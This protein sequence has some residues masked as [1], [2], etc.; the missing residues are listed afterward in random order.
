MESSKLHTNQDRKTVINVDSILQAQSRR[1]KSTEVSKNILPEVDLGNLLLI[2]RQPVD[3]Q[4]L[5]SDIEISLQQLARDNTQWLINEIWKLPTQQMEDA[6][7]VQ[8]PEPTTI[9]AREK[10]IPKP[11]PPTKWEQYAKAKGIQKRKRGKMTF[12]EKTQTYKRRWGYK[13]VTDDSN[14]WVKEVPENAD[15]YEDQFEVAR[16][17]KKER[18]AKN[19][20]QRLRNIERRQKGKSMKTKAAQEEVTKAIKDAQSSTASHGVFTK[21]LPQE[22]RLRKAGVRRKLPPNLG[23]VKSERGAGLEIADKLRKAPILNIPKAVSMNPV[24][25]DGKKS[26]KGRKSKGNF[27]QGK[28]AKMSNRNFSQKTKKSSAISRS[29]KK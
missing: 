2:D 15:P 13:S 21:I 7:L 26:K 19:E 28:R 5:Q 18:I 10:P 3:P 6:L 17:A 1:Y 29:K 9:V 27:R 4:E 20:L 14:D 23:D 22:K 12:D 24:E 25:E 16:E 11:K 8:L